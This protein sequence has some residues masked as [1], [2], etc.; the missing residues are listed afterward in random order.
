MKS[1]LL[2]ITCIYKNILNINKTK[3]MY[4][5]MK[6]MFYYVCLKISNMQTISLTNRSVNTC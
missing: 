3:C 2:K 4:Y 6:L 1:V 5:C